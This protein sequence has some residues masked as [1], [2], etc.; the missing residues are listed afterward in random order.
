MCQREAGEPAV[1][2]RRL[3]G[4]RCRASSRSTEGNVSTCCTTTMALNSSRGSAVLGSG[5]P[6]TMSTVRIAWGWEFWIV[7]WATPA[8]SS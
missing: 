4:P 7:T 2:F 8:V 6:S 3:G 1:E 5:Q